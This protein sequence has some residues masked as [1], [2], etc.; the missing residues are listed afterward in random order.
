MKNLHF[1]ISKYAQQ[2]PISMQYISYDSSKYEPKGVR[3][4]K[5]LEI[6]FKMSKEPPKK[7]FKT[8]LNDFEH[9]I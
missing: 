9:D 7:P 2:L 3:I 1:V 4:N 8:S 5:Y 6:V